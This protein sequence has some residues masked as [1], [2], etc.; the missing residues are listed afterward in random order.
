MGGGYLF[1]IVLKC[2]VRKH[3]I[4]L[5]FNLSLLIS[6]IKKPTLKRQALEKEAGKRIILCMFFYI[7]T[8]GA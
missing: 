6:L 3:K 5:N 4:Y 7:Y 1:M 8:Y 2:Q